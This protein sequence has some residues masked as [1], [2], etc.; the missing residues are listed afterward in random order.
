MPLNRA[1]PA[2][3]IVNELV[4]NSI[5]RGFGNAG[6]SIR[7]SFEV[8]SNSSEACLCVDDD[9]TGM[10][11]PPAT[12]VGFKLIKGL[13]HQLGG[14]VEHLEVERGTRTRVCFPVAFGER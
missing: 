4:T 12:G 8:L 3:L 5:R 2:G 11:L 10:K 6:G 13:A 7:V 9:G 1:V 14:R